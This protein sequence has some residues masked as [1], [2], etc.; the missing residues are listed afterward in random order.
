MEFLHITLGPIAGI[1]NGSGLVQ[2]VSIFTESRYINRGVVFDSVVGWVTERNKQSGPRYQRQ[3]VL[4][5]A[6]DVGRLAGV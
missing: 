2:P 4:L 5:E 3:I 1:Y 6:E